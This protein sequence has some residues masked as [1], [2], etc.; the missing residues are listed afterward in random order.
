MMLDMDADEDDERLSHP[1]RQ[2]D[3]IVDL[4][5]NRVNRKKTRHIRPR[6]MIDKNRLELLENERH[7][8][9]RTLLLFK[10]LLLLRGRLL[11]QLLYLMGRLWDG[12]RLCVVRPRAVEARV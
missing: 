3:C 11:V 7:S 8:I 6:S 5:A 1:H 10:L 9:E 12:S 2:A 4:P